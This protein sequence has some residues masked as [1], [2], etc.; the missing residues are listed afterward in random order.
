M[1]KYFFLRIIVLCSIA[2]VHIG[3]AV[4]GGPVQEALV[5]Q[6]AV[7]EE[8]IGM[9]GLEALSGLTEAEER[10]E[11]AAEKIRAKPIMG[12]ALEALGEITEEYPAVEK[13]AAE[14]EEIRKKSNEIQA[15]IEASINEVED[16]DLHTELENMVK[17]KKRKMARIKARLTRK[18]ER[19]AQRQ[20]KKAGLSGPV[21]QISQQLIEAKEK[22]KWV[23]KYYETIL[24][25]VLMEEKKEIAR[26]KAAHRILQQKTAALMGERPTPEEVAP[27]QEPAITPAATE[28][29]RPG[30]GI[31]EEI[32]EAKRASLQK[33]VEEI[34]RKHKEANKLWSEHKKKRDE[35]SDAG[36]K[37][38]FAA[39]ARESEIR[40]SILNVKSTHMKRRLA[41]L[42][43][44]DLTEIEAEYKK[45]SQDAEPEDVSLRVKYFAALQDVRNTKKYLNDISRAVKR[46]QGGEIELEGGEFEDAK[47]ER[48]DAKE[49]LSTAKKAVVR[50]MVE[51]GDID[52]FKEVASKSARRYFF[53]DERENQVSILVL[54]IKAPKKA[55]EL[56]EAILE[57]GAKPAIAYKVGEGKDK[58]LHFAVRSK[59]NPLGLTQALLSA[60]G[61]KVNAKGRRGATAL[62]WAIRAKEDRLEIVKKLLSAGADP[63]IKDDLSKIPLHIA[64]RVRNVVPGMVEALLFRGADPGAKDSQGRTPLEM[65]VKRLVRESKKGDLSDEFRRVLIMLNKKSRSP[66]RAEAK[67]AVAKERRALGRGN[68]DRV[69]RLRVILGLLRAPRN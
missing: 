16:P 64:V 61:V 60:R 26:K 30:A 51:S 8:R 25:P 5:G 32:M 49:R 55:L 54:A 7:E 1:K 35:T 6:E 3:Q 47:A 17:A 23:K 38:E 42:N 14:T 34:K 62:H 9:R 18:A 27:T 20:V 50:V 28:E 33:R 11:A 45:V 43:A 21:A 40:V 24:Y 69:V 48:D 4:C 56:T 37:E 36:E 31:I 63:N 67:K 12:M 22:M 10:E 29:G 44:A 19:I 65:F 68:P 53:P 15:E 41:N 58:P 13:L 46:L 2:C 59:V 52:G 39:F 66:E 57:F